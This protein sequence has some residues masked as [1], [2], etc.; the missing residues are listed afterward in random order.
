MPDLSHRWEPMSTYR[1]VDPIPD[2]VI[3]LHMNNG[4]VQVSL[5]S[6]VHEETAEFL[7]GDPSHEGWWSYISRIAQDKI[8][9]PLYWMPVTVP[10]DVIDRVL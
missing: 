4:A 10:Q 3:L 8:D 7:M 5:A 9:E 1:N 6:Y 2:P